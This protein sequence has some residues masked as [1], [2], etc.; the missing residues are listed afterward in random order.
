MKQTFEEMW[1]DIVAS[2]KLES[3][4]WEPS[5]RL[6]EMVRDAYEGR[7]TFDSVGKELVEFHR[8]KNA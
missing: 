4:D 5:E 1:R 3:P 2:A 8:N 6:T 7:R